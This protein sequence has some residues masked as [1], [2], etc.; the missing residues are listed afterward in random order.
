MPSHVKKIRKYRDTILAGL[1]ES[2]SELVEEQLNKMLSYFLK[3][4]END[5]KKISNL[6]KVQLF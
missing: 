2:N 1:D 4:A 6:I 5:T 3:A